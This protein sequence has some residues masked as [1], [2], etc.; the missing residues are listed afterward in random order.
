MAKHP[1]FERPNDTITLSVQILGGDN[2][3]TVDA[4]SAAKLTNFLPIAARFAAE[5]LIITSLASGTTY[6]VTRA[7]AGSAVDHAVSVVGYLVHSFEGNNRQ[8][9]YAHHADT[10]LALS[11]AL[12]DVAT[13]MTLTGV[14]PRLPCY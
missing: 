1:L 2:T 3:I 4:G 9:A 12:T 10:Q 11:G 13:Q 6:N 5:T 14:L 7:V 8:T